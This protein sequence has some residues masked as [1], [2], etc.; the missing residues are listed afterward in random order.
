M[1]K[2]VFRYHTLLN[3]RKITCYIKDKQLSHECGAIYYIVYIP[4]MSVKATFFLSTYLTE[5][6]KRT[7]VGSRVSY[8]YT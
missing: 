3:K 2:N 1:A 8:P 6:L 4:M 7:S 5:N